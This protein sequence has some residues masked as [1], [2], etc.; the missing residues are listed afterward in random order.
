MI[1]VIVPMWNHPDVTAAMLASCVPPGDGEMVEVI[2]VDN[3][4]TD[5]ACAPIGAEPPVPDGVRVRVLHNRVNVGYPYAVNQGLAA[6]DPASDV[7]VMAHNDIQLP[8][9]GLADLAAAVRSG[10]E[11]VGPASATVSGVQQVGIT[12]PPE[13]FPDTARWWR[14]RTPHTVLPLTRLAGFCVA[15]S[16]RALDRI[17][18]YDP[19]FSPGHF[20]EDDWAV[21]ARLAGM[22]TGYA[23][24]ILVHHADS[25]SFDAASSAYQDLL[26]RHHALFAH[27]WRRPEATDDLRVPLL[28]PPLPRETG[29]GPERWAVADGTAPDAGYTRL[30]AETTGPLRVLVDPVGFP[31]PD[32]ADA[33]FI[34]WV[35]TYPW[36]RFCEWVG[37]S[38]AAPVF[39]GHP[40]E[41]MFQC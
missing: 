36:L 30:N 14:D 31:W 17:G 11:A 18:G 39:V 23:P 32:G 35:E 20:E 38:G 16:R 41:P 19:R 1:S 8:P 2:L 25:Q 9:T 33:R 34:P 26:A 22:K 15:V 29:T 5:P 13:R 6:T 10:W 12:Y 28:L 3:A 40:W 7:L 27:K 24:W 21:R 37:S 4:S